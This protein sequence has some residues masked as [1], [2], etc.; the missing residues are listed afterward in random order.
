MTIDHNFDNFQKI[1]CHRSETHQNRSD[2][3]DDIPGHL[4]ISFSAEVLYKNRTK[5]VKNNFSK[6]GFRNSTGFYPRSW[7]TNPTETSNMKI[8]TQTCHTPT[9]NSPRIGFDDFKWNLCG[10]DR[11]SFEGYMAER[12]SKIIVAMVDATVAKV[13]NDHKEYHDEISCEKMAFR[14]GVGWT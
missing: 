10:L 5:T 7:P 11:A 6:V 1:D 12:I 8:S 4:S 13:Y 14:L 3:S 9:P 2:Q